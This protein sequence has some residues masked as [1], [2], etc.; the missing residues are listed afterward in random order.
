L[1]TAS[2]GL[3][4]PDFPTFRQFNN[5]VVKVILNEKEVL[6]DATDKFRP[7]N[8]L[9]ESCLNGKGLV[10]REGDAE[11]VAMNMNKEMSI[12]SMVV[13]YDVDEFGEMSGSGSIHSPGL[14]GAMIKAGLVNEDEDELEESLQSRLNEFELSNIKYSGIDDS[15]SALKRTFDFS[16]ETFGDVI[17]DRIF[18]TPLILK[19]LEENPFRSSERTLAIDFPMPVNRRYLF[20]I[21]IPEGYEVEG[22][23]KNVQYALPGNGGT[24]SYLSE[25]KKNVINVVVRFTINKVVF[26]PQEYDHIR[27]MFNLILAKQEERIVLKKKSD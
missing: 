24:Y 8:I 14:S 26:N 22:I 13:N 25:K 17:G 2:H 1:S 6:M 18:F 5:V 10:V 9:P 12:Q 21:N 11:W 19:E 16:A 7:Y 20:T 15:Y 3:I 4:N 27:E 23:P